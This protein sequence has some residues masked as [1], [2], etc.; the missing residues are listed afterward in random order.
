MSER[1]KFIGRLAEKKRE[2]RGMR[3]KMSGLVT[4]IR[5]LLDPFGEVED[6]IT[7]V[8]A[9]QAVELDTLKIDYKALQAEITAIEKALGE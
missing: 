3:L 9:A 1:L 6:I 5:G 7:D 2:L 4:S 8:A